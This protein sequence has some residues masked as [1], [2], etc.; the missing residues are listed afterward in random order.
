MDIIQNLNFRLM[1]KKH[2]YTWGT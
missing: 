2:Y 1:I